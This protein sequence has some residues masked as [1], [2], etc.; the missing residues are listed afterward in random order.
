MISIYSMYPKTLFLGFPVISL[1][2]DKP[3]SGGNLIL[4]QRLVNLQDR[5]G[6]LSETVL[7]ES[8]IPSG[9]CRELLGRIH[10]LFRRDFDPVS[11]KLQPF[12]PHTFRADLGQQVVIVLSMILEEVAQ[13]QQGLT[14]Q[15]LLAEY[16]GDKQSAQPAVAVQKWVN[17]LKLHM[18]QRGLEKGRR[19]NRLVVQEQFKLPECIQNTIRRWWDIYGIARP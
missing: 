17:R 4:E 3:A 8:V 13:V 10:C 6:A 15:L 2:E 18:R 5:C 11:K 1:I 9:K 12:L 14:K 16:E 19:S 7:D